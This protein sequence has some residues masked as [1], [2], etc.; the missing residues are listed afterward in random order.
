MIVRLDDDSFGGRDVSNL[1]SPRRTRPPGIAYKPDTD[2]D[3][4]SRPVSPGGLE[5]ASAL[6]WTSHYA[7][8]LTM[9]FTPPSQ[10]HLRGSNKRRR[11]VAIN[12]YQLLLR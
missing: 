10:P 2:R 3:K 11:S 7:A 9:P 12:V 5:L 8:A 4:T 6:D 1:V